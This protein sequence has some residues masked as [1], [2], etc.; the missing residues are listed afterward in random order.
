MGTYCSDT[1]LT[2]VKE[3]LHGVINMWLFSYAEF[4]PYIKNCL[5]SPTCN[6]LCNIKRKMSKCI[7]SLFELRNLAHNRS[8]QWPP[9]GHSRVSLPDLPLQ[10]TGHMFQMFCCSPNG[11][12][13]FWGSGMGCLTIKASVSWRRCTWV[14]SPPFWC[15]SFCLSVFFGLFIYLST[16]ASLA[17]CL[18]VVIPVFDINPLLFYWCYL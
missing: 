9:V 17:V 2:L 18:S 12:V 13:L 3:N 11:I 1:F 15:L 5:F 6:S 8:D 16:L 10:T 14:S 7:W 4:P